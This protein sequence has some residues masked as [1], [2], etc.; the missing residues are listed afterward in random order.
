MSLQWSCT[1]AHLATS[2]VENWQKVLTEVSSEEAT[3]MTSTSRSI[4]TPRAI[5]LRWVATLPWELIRFMMN[6]HSIGTLKENH[7]GTGEIRKPAHWCSDMKE[8]FICSASRSYVSYLNL[9][10][11]KNYNINCYT[12]VNNYGSNNGDCLTSNWMK[13]IWQLFR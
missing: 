7:R 9:K 8:L 12:T 11:K 10:F 13:L 5:R 1:A 3:Q 2:C 4:T 6:T